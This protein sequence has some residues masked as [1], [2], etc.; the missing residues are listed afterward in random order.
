MKSLS[1]AEDARRNDEETRIFLLWKQNQ[2]LYYH[3]IVVRSVGHKG[4]PIAGM[5]VESRCDIFSSLFSAFGIFLQYH[6][7]VLRVVFRR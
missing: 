4:R 7:F 2:Q 1:A 6:V 5:A 3:A